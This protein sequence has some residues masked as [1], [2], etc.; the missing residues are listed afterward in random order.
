MDISQHTTVK[1][2]QLNADDLI[3]S[4]ITVKITRVVHGNA[5]QPVVVHL[6]GGY[7]PWKPCKTMLRVLMYAWG[8]HSEAYIGRRVTLFRE[9]TARFGGQEVG[10]IR[11]SHMSHIDKP[12]TLSVTIRRGHKVPFKVGA[13]KTEEAP[14]LD[15]LLEAAGVTRDDVDRWLKSCNQATLSEASHDDLPGWLAA[16]PKRFDPIKALMGGDS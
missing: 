16:D 15:A 8:K 2:D 13:L 3:G 14:D 4:P 11:I 1:S 5:D 12:M 9:P 7:Q 10:G 6:D